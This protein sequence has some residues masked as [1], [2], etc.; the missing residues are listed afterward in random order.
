MDALFK[1]LLEWISANPEW[2]YLVVFSV[3]FSESVAIVGMIV[4]GVMIMIGAGALI[5]TG[6]LAFLPT[7]SAAV[8]GAIAGDGLSYWIGRHYRDQLRTCWPFNRYPAQLDQGIAF[9]ERHGAKSVVFGR[10]FGPVRAIIPLVAGMLHMPRG[11]FAFA[12]VSSAIAWGPTYLA[13]GIVFGASLKLAAEAAARLVIL[14]VALIGLIWLAAWIA[15]RLFFLITPHVSGWVQTLLRW[16]DLHPAFGRIAQALADPEHPD[17]ATL[18]GLAVLLVGATAMLTVTI[19]AGL[20]GAQ[21]LVVNQVTLELG[22]SLHAPLANQVMLALSRLGEPEMTVPMVVAILVFLLASGQRRTLQYWL[23]ALAFTLLAP[24]VL[25]WLVKA[26]RPSIGLDLPWP[27]SFPSAQV[28]SATVLYGLLALSLSRTLAPGWRWSPHAAAAMAI[29]AVASARVYF[30][31]EWLT[32]VLGTIALGL[33]WT[34]ALGLALY[35]HTSEPAQSTGLTLVTISAAIIAFTAA[36]LAQQQP[37]L[38]R[39]TPTVAWQSVN[40]SDWRARAPIPVAEQ[41][42]DLWRRNR[43]AFDVQYAGQ[44]DRLET[45]LADRGWEPAETLGWKNAIRLLSPSLPLAALPVVPHVHDGHHDDLTLV[46]NLPDDRRLVLRLWSTHI[47]LDGS[48][49][50]WV[51]DVTEL[52]KDNVVDLVALPL[53]KQARGLGN[54]TLNDDLEQTP[55]INVSAGAPM[56]LA[57]AATGLLQTRPG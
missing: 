26:P 57:P 55:A 11:R 10:F 40:S 45:A 36:S 4:P 7:A 53:T 12:N 46:K 30:G 5:A 14:L 49:P 54:R 15:R 38:Q 31:A 51:G 13:P 22:Q 17:A 44:L 21:D 8:I 19:S 29:T 35:R 39:Y 6:D 52:T 48:I 43:R 50:L 56:L 37:D 28:L 41:R 27:W 25:G 32:D 33:T 18:A 34:A 24:P 9:F 1:Q 16:G 42:K 2:A 23:A 20:A 47:R 3:A